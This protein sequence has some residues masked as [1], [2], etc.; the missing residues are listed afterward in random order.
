MER[1]NELKRKLRHLKRLELK[2]RFAGNAPNQDRLIWGQFFS[3]QPTELKCKY[4]FTA[5]AEDNEYRRRAFEDFITTLYSQYFRERGM[6]DTS[7]PLTLAEFD[8]PPFASLKELKARFRELVKKNHPDLGGDHHR[9]VE[10]LRQYHKLMED[11][12]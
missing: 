12:K 2:L 9:M 3:V 1:E 6:L 5:L 11:H 7:D 4:P 8:L 10:L